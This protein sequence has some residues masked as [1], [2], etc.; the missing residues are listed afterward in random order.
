M[1]VRFKNR[2]PELIT[3]AILIV[4]IAAIELRRKPFHL[5]PQA[6]TS[7]ATE[8]EHY[9]RLVRDSSGDTL[10]MATPPRRIGSE[11][12]GSD[13]VLF[14][15]CAG[16]RLVGVSSVALDD[17]YS[18]VA[19]EVKSLS[20]HNGGFVTRSENVTITYDRSMEIPNAVH[21]DMVSAGG[22][23]SN[24]QT[25]QFNLVSDSFATK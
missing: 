20:I 3:V 15:V 17:R 25:F 24:H 1:P 14:G 10:A 4:A 2:L 18:N 9:P 23:S 21:D 19:E 22:S 16:D 6:Q 13:E 11:T 5:S 8:D 12:L 7:A